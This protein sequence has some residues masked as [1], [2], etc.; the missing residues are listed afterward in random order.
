[1]RMHLAIVLLVSLAAAPAAAQICGDATNDDTVTVTDGVQALRSA[2]GLSSSCEDGC[3]ID[4]SGAVTVSDGVNILRKA[5][6]LTINEA[7]DFTGQDA[8]GLTNPAFSVFDGI[9]KVPGIGAGAGAAAGACEND[10]T[11]ETSQAGEISSATFNEC[12]IQGAILNGTISRAVFSQAAVVALDGFRITRIKTGKTLSFSGQLGLTVVPGGKRLVGTLTVTT[13]S[14]GTFTIRFERILLA[15]DGSVRQGRLLYDLTKSE[16]ERIATIVITF[17]EDG[18]DLPVS[19]AL[20][21]K[22]VKQFLLNRGT[23][24]LIPAV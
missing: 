7:C 12:Q 8:N 4:A 9:T 15:G 23:R 17:D 1:M 18:D 13:E 2:A 14:F 16:S 10:G 3:D 11:I 6:G 5:A 22:K 21:N 20:R 19:V 24:L